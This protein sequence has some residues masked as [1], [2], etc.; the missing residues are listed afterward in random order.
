MNLLW[1]L[2]NS[3]QISVRSPLMRLKFPS[4]CQSFFSTL[5]IVTN[6]D[7]IPSTTLNYLLFKMDPSDPINDRFNDMDIF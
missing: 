3:L 1:G 5:F 2:I 4:H 7:I 6:F